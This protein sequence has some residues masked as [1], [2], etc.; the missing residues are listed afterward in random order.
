MLCF[1][2]RHGDHNLIVE[3]GKSRALSIDHRHSTNIQKHS[4]ITCSRLHIWYVLVSY[5]HFS[6]FFCRVEFNIVMRIIT[7]IVRHLYLACDPV[8]ATLFVPSP[9]TRYVETVRHAAVPLKF[10]WHFPMRESMSLDN[11][12]TTPFAM[13]KE[14]DSSATINPR[15]FPLRKPITH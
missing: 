13:Q 1:C 9:K 7:V 15:N 8:D 12:P 6:D 4:N 3:V 14:V 5:F 10:S 2:T 11:H